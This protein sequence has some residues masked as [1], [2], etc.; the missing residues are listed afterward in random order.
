MTELPPVSQHYPSLPSILRKYD[1][2]ARG[3]RFTGEDRETL[4]SWQRAAREK[5]SGL[6]GLE[7]MEG[8][9]LEPECTETVTLPNGIRRERWTIQTEPDVTMPFYLLIPPGADRTTR[10][11]LCPPG[12]GGAG[13]YSVAGLREFGAVAEKIDLY[14]YDYGLQL[15]CLGYV[16]LCPDCRGFGERRE[17]PGDT[18]TLPAAPL[19]NCR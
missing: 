6:L 19:L 1:R 9:P 2:Y 8:C 4:L 15:A 16:A 3:M 7:K 12:H 10:P 17:E 11:F 14:N 5:L 13:K 18:R